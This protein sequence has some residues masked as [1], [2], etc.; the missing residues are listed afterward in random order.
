MATGA[1]TLD[2]SKSVP[3]NG[4]K[5]ATPTTSAPTTPTAPTLDFSKAEPA[6]QKLVSPEGKVVYAQSDEQTAA[7]KAKGHTLVN[8]DGSFYL[9]NIP[10]EDPLEEE[11]RRQ[12]VYSAL[13][14]QEKSGAIKNELRE[15]RS[16]MTDAALYTASG[17]SGASSLGAGLSALGETEALQLLKSSPKLYAEYLLKSPAAKTVAKQGVKLLL[18]QSVNIGLAGKIFGW[19]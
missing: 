11:K 7:L 19:W 13:T 16:A 12:R 1:V 18:K 17:V 3:I 5:D 2:F 10:G 4:T 9:Q 15:A 14:P 8:P 6:G